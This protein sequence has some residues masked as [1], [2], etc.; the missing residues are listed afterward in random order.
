MSARP[1]NQWLQP[2]DAMMA[3]GG[4]LRQAG[5]ARGV[6]QQRAVG[7]ASRRGAPRRRVRRRR[8]RRARG[9]CGARRQRRRRGARLRASAPR[10]RSLRRKLRR[11][12]A[13][14]IT[15]RAAATSRQWASAAPVRFDVDAAR[16]RRRPASGRARS[17]NIR[18]DWPSAARPSRPSRRFAASAQRE[19]LVHPRASARKLKRLALAEQ[20]RLVAVAARPFADCASGRVRSGSRRRARQS[21]RARAARRARASSRRGGGATGSFSQRLEAAAPMEQRGVVV[22]APHRRDR[23]MT[24]A[25]VWRSRISSTRQSIAASA[26]PSSGAPVTSVDPVALA[27]RA[28]PCTPPRPAKRSASASCRAPRILTAKAP[29]SRRRASVVALRSMQT[30]SEG[31][32][33][34][35]EESAVAVQPARCRRAAGDDRDASGEFAHREAKR[36]ALGVGRRSAHAIDFVI[37]TGAFEIVHRRRPSSRPTGRPQT[38]SHCAPP[39]ARAIAVEPIAKSRTARLAP[40]RGVDR[41]RRGGKVACVRGARPQGGLGGEVVQRGGDRRGEI[42]FRR[43][44][45]DRGFAAQEAQHVAAIFARQRVGV[46]FGMALQEDEQ[47]AA[48]ACTKMSTPA[49]ARARQGSD[50][51]WRR[52]RPRRAVVA[53]MRRHELGVEACERVR[54][55][56]ATSN[57]EDAGAF[58]RQPAARD[59]VAA[60]HRGM[61]GQAREDGRERSRVG[62]VE[63]AGRVRASRAPAQDRPRAARRR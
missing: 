59:A 21:S 39:C 13:S 28:A 51:P 24:I 1:A 30:S 9:R 19:Y 32:V 42:V 2:I 52:A 12:G 61:R 27:K 63:H 35:S 10:R 46:V 4:R 62:P 43:A 48:S 34:D 40:R 50:S 15:R 16:R 41:Q 29:H 57:G 55:R 26:S 58:G 5:R 60:Q 11:T 31:G 22:A 54:G 49:S 6:D 38:T 53:R 3:D 36:R 25:W 37:A 45:H 7:E 47:A 14:T 20:R 8:A 23:P 44:R 56:R 17:R 33:S 18:A